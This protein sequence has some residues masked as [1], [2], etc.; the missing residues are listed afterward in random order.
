MKH[1]IFVFDLKM[2]PTAR[3]DRFPKLIAFSGFL[4][5]FAFDRPTKALKDFSTAC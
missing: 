1:H 2:V 5:F 4:E 3:D